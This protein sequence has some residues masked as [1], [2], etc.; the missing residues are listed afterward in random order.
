MAS[1]REPDASRVTDSVFGARVAGGLAAAAT[2]CL[3]L[4]IVL[5]LSARVPDRVERVLAEPQDQWVAR[6]VPIFGTTYSGA[7]GHRYGVYQIL[8][9]TH[10]AGAVIGHGELRL[11]VASYDL[12]ADLDR[13]AAAFKGTNCEY[14]T[15][16]GATF[17]NNTPLTL[18]RGDGC[19]PLHGDPTGEVE[20]TVRLH[21]SARLGLWTY[22]V[23]PGSPIPDSA[24][25]VK[26][27]D[28]VPVATLVVMGRGVDVFP[29]SGRKRIELLAYMWQ[30]GSGPRWIWATVGACAVLVCAG[31]VL[32]LSGHA[33]GAFGVAAGLGVLY[34]VMTPPFHAPDE[35]HHFRDFA[36]VNGR[37]DLVS[38]ASEVARLGQFERIQFH[39]EEQFRPSD[40]GHPG[41]RWNDDSPP[42]DL[43]GTGVHVLWKLVGPA[44]ARRSAS[45]VLLGVRVFNAV[46]LG[47]AAALAVHLAGRHRSA[48]PGPL[49]VA[50]VLL[51]PALP[52]LGMH[53]SNYGPLISVY[54]L[55]AAGVLLLVSDRGN[56]VLGGAVMAAS[57]ATATLL[58]RSALPLVGMILALLTARVILGR[59]HASSTRTV[60]FWTAVTLPMVVLL[61]A[62]SEYMQ[63]QG[64]RAA[65]ALAPGVAL[66]VQWF[67]RNPAAVC[68]LTAAAAT[69]EIAMGAVKARA[70]VR[71]RAWTEVS[72]RV[73][74][75][76]GAAVIAIVA[77]ASL[78]L[79]YPSLRTLNWI[80]PPPV[81]E[82]VK[83][84][85]PVILTIGRLRNPDLLTSVTFWGGFGWLETR[86]PDWF[87]TVLAGA[88]CLAAIVLL[89]RTARGSDA[90]RAAW[91]AALFG[92]FVASTVLYGIMVMTAVP[93]IDLHGRYLFGLYL[94]VV[95]VAWSWSWETGL[96]ARH[97]RIAAAGWA[98]AIAAINGYCLRLILQRYF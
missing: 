42:V 53:F 65:P 83:G 21:N 37:P 77:I 18:V 26:G 71:M 49:L 67:L 93:V 31:L 10:D 36:A 84:V 14:H 12:F 22:L 35:P 90:R 56:D 75:W 6:A 79:R 39:P 58:S 81:S 19:V 89:A 98:F 8:L 76:L 55:F 23:S 94:P 38:G 80:G 92:G 48:P 1:E 85:V 78:V 86:P 68:L 50:S 43:R 47:L 51:V 69:I 61:W 15:R 4:P 45:Q 52:F 20:L 11:R 5:A 97:R 40:I 73:V 9:S 70:G 32:W 74:L 62:G 46:L 96:A 13:A 3:L 25:I 72:A 41:E 27:R 7:D 29:A 60:A 66:V 24:L 95:L 57:W 2:L 63:Q 54:I 33:A 16:S 17:P 28:P 88:T 91:L 64:V 30:I 87:I 44:L 59:Q 34:A 82:Y